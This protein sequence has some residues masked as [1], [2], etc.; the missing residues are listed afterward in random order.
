M[1]PASSA[2]ADGPPSQ[3]KEGKYW[4]SRP[5]EGHVSPGAGLVAG[6]LLA[7]ST[8]SESDISLEADCST[9]TLPPQDASMRTAQ[10]DAA[11]RRETRLLI[12]VPGGMTGASTSRHPAFSHSASARHSTEATHGWSSV[13]TCSWTPRIAGHSSVVSQP[14]YLHKPPEQTSVCSHCESV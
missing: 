14:M 7:A 5:G 12:R 9:P 11:A 10:A 8:V 4:H 13:V 2:R 1:L 6:Q 3:Q